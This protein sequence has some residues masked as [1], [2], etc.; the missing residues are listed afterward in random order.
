MVR[1]AQLS[2]VDALAQLW[3]CGWRKA[4]QHV[5]RIETAEGVFE[6]PH[7]RFEKQVVSS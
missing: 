1:Q 6:V 7:W 3:K 5:N 2:E 4:D